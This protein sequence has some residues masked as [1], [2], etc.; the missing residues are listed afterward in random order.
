[1][2][3]LLVIKKE[4]NR[5]RQDIK[6]KYLLENAKVRSKTHYEAA[7]VYSAGQKITL[8]DA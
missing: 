8:V 7:Y 1:M 6:R 4:E 3:L 5:Y 2:G